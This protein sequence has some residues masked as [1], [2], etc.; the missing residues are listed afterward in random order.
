MSA[1]FLGLAGFYGSVDYRQE[2][3]FSSKARP[4]VVFER[5][6]RRELSHS[7][8]G[9]FAVLFAIM[10][11]TQ[12][13]RLLNDAVGG[14]VAPD[15]VAALLG[16][17][18]LQYLPTLLGLTLFTTILVTLSR[19][20]RDSEMVIWFS[21]GNSLFKWVRPVLRFAAPIVLLIAALAFVFTPWGIEKSAEFKQKANSRSEAT[22]ISPG[23]F[24]ETT[25]SNRVVFVESIDDE[26][27]VVKGVFVRSLENGRL[28]IVTA[29]E[30]RKH[31]M[32][33]GDRFLV[34]DKGRRYEM[35]PGS[36]ELRS[37][38][39]ARYAVRIE[40]KESYQPVRSIRQMTTPDLIRSPDRSASAELVWRVGLPL[41]AIML[42]LMAIPLAYV[43]PR[44]GRSWGVIVALLVFIIYNNLQ[45]VMQSWVGQ[46]RVPAVWGMWVIHGVVF[47]G[48]LLMAW[49]QIQVGKGWRWWR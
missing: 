27:G 48:F 30:G 25:A 20:Y 35:I 45:S 40:L 6:L 36:P 19:Q 5:A 43:N 7:A 3:T 22:H 16:F 26:K 29:D 44:G 8:I 46:G 11:A 24:R 38:E 14:R 10:L 9:I 32:E 31:T 28:V 34:L 2:L 12:L 49:R 15:A 18:A 47:A 39:F 21:S 33:N 4:K 23:A 17:T 1:I 37:I 42:S 13:V 41:S